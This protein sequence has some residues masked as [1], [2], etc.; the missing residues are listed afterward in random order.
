MYSH[1]TTAKPCSPPPQSPRLLDQVRECIRYKH[2]SLRT[3][4]AYVYWVRAFI[5]FHRLKHPREMG[6]AE[7][8]AFLS[9]LATHRQVSVSTHQQ[10]LSA[11][12]FLYRAVLGQELPWMDEIVRPKRRER[13]PSVLT[14]DEIR[15]LLAAMEGTEA[16]LA[17]LLFGT[18]LRLSEALALRVKDVDF[19]RN[20]ITVREGKGGK[21]RRV[22]LPASLKRALQSQVELARRVWTT[23]RA[24]GLPGVFLPHAL[25]RKYPK[26]GESFAWFWVWP[27]PSLS[28]D[29]RS[30]I[31]RRHHLYE[32]RLQRA[33]KRAV[34]TARID[35][36]VSVHTL[37]HSFATHLLESGYDIRTVQELLGHSDVS[38]TMIYTH[39]LNRGGRG[40]VSPLDRLAH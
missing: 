1:K 40:V 34:A 17:R 26:A 5:R 4:Q 24:K 10:A 15:A 18:G 19:G 36:P 13:V 21:D 27:S 14:L 11:L 16:L 31:R 25:E 8:T 23:D 32:Q 30:G 28:V 39:V 33:V 6:G 9:W 38:T 20:E 22:M 12:L 2:Y 29:P 35:K 3:E 7:V 37:R